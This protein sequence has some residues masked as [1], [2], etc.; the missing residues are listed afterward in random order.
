MSNSILRLNQV[1]V[2]LDGR[3]TLPKGDITGINIRNILENPLVGKTFGGA[4]HA[5]AIPG[6]R[7]FSITVIA[8]SQAQ[9]IL[10]NLSSELDVN[11][12][13]HSF[14]FYDGSKTTVECK[15]VLCKD[16]SV[17]MSPDA[18]IEYEYMFSS[19]DCSMAVNDE[20]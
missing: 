20:Q 1:A 10:S 17:S 3:I 7:E 11:P 5:I 16:V 8:E 9:Q 15:K 18:V 6:E 12:R 2:V 19:L 4:Y 13:H 14:T